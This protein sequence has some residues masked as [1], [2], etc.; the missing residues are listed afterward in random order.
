MESLPAS[1]ASKCRAASLTGWT[2]AVA[3]A[4]V[5]SLDA[6]GESTFDALQKRG[7]SP[8]GLRA[9]DVASD[10]SIENVPPGD[11]V[12]LAAFENDDLV[13]DPDESIG[14]PSSAPALR[15][16]IRSPTPRRPLSGP[17]TPRRAATSCAS[18][19]RLVSW[20]TKPSTCL[21]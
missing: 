3:G 6:N 21:L 1:R 14:G 19:T 11:Y 9:G 12:V 8:A 17:T 7:E 20:C 18:M 2:T 15:A 13:R 10:F 4:T 5:V 16:S